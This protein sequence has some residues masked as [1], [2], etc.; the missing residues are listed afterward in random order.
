[1][2]FY[3]VWYLRQARYICTT[4]SMMIRPAVAIFS[5]APKLFIAMRS[6]RAYLI[7]LF[8]LKRAT[9]FL[10]CL[11]SF[12]AATRTLARKQRVLQRPMS[13]NQKH[14]RCWIFLRLYSFTYLA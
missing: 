4:F 6:C 14:M 7:F 8:F 1:M 9:N 12:V 10:T 11:C 13:R 5:I 3:S 2:Y